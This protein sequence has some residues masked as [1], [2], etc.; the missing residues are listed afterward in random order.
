MVAALVSAKNKQAATD[1]EEL[2]SH[3]ERAGAAIVGRVVQRRGVSRSP[4]AG[5]VARMNS[6]MSAATVL[7]SG[8]VK[9]LAEMVV[10]REASVVVFLNDLKDTQRVRLEDELGCRVLSSQ[11]LGPG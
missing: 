5:G 9:E 8:K 7:G 4:K 10:A 2:E 3:V 1:L 11:D 6:P